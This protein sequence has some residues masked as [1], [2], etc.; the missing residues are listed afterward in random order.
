MSAT[1]L[2]RRVDSAPRQ[3]MSVD[4][5][6]NIKKERIEV[7]FGD[8]LPSTSAN[9]GDVALASGLARTFALPH[10]PRGIRLVTPPL[11]R[12]MSFVTEQRWQGHVT[13]VGDQ[14]FHAMVYDTAKGSGEVEDVEI[15]KSAVAEL[16]RPLI[17]EGGVFFWDI[18]FTVKPSGERNQQMIV[19]FPM[20]PTDS[21]KDRREAAERA[22][23][24][25]KTLGW[26]REIAQSSDAKEA[27]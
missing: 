8:N 3:D 23:I 5:P 16:M 13:R 24:K 11:D 10:L 20:I 27:T 18:G 22:K 9:A 2:A 14:T 15:Q 17:V 19:S 12:L 7:A 25:F 21:K 6:S 1:A 26:D 4:V